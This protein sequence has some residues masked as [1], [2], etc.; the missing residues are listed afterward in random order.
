MDETDR[1]K[2]WGVGIVLRDGKT[3]RV[4]SGTSLIRTAR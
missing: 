3:M 1:A 4:L 2:L